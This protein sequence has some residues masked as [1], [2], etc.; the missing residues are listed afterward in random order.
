MDQLSK[1]K[2]TILTKDVFSDELQKDVKR[3]L[4]DRFEDFVKNDWLHDDDAKTMPLHIH[5]VDPK[6]T[7][8]IKGGLQDK[9]I[10]LTKGLY[11]IFR[12]D[13]NGQERMRVLIL[14]I[15]L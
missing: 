12:D 8:T 11:Q 15:N 1:F 7:K 14:G 13:Q 10:P 3:A 6:W 5:Y 9:H 2:T 4:I